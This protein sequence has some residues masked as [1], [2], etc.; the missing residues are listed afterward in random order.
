MEKPID[1]DGDMLAMGL[2]FKWKFISSKFKGSFKKNKNS[3]FFKFLEEKN[4]KE[5]ESE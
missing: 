1:V 2:I 4:G 5:N 3:L